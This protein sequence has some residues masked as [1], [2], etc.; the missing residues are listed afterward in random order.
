MKYPRI[1]SEVINGAWFMNPDSIQG[2]LPIISQLLKGE[3]IEL[4]SEEKADQDPVHMIALLN[5]EGMVVKEMNSYRINY[6]DFR[7]IPENS[8]IIIPV[9]DVITKYNYCGAPGTLTLANF[10]KEADKNQNI[11][12]ILFDIDSPGGEAAGTEHFANTI[13][14]CKTPTLAFVNGMVASAAY[15]P[16]SACDEI[17]VNLKT[18]YVGSIGTYRNFV[19]FTEYYEKE[20]IIVKDIYARVS[21]EKNE[22]HREALKGN[23][24]PMLDRMAVITQSLID[25]VKKGRGDRLNS[26]KGDPF[27]GKIYFAAEAL[28]IGLIDSINNIEYAL[29]RLKTGSVLKSGSD[30]EDTIIEEELSEKNNS[31]T[32]IT[33]SKKLF[34]Y[35]AA[36]L[37]VESFEATEKEGVYLNEE[38]MAALNSKLEAGEQA[39]TQLAE[40]NPKLET[41]SSRV[42]ELEA[43]NTELTEKLAAKPAEKIADDKSKEDK[44]G[45][46]DTYQKVDPVYEELDNI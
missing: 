9:K 14:E 10:I 12:G 31:N 2:Y 45:L 27:K 37:G 11:T 5:S 32:K 21:T 4:Q 28:E 26:E 17:V 38:Q 7:D 42:T 41:A 18:D 30:P 13:A 34:P 16:A 36:A 40:V 25:G 35:V 3:R 6:N 24:E 39:A 20:G 22:E 44:G 29:D 46:E 23:F 19:D 8:T 33:M 43:E 15:W 1:L